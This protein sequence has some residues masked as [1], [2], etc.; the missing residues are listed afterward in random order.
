MEKSIGW[1]RAH[2]GEFIFRSA[3]SWIL[4][5]ALM[6]IAQPGEGYK[7]VRR[8]IELWRSP[9]LGADRTSGITI[10]RTK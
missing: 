3:P 9:R 7:V 1:I 8:L 4:A 6:P 2:A 10:R 5:T